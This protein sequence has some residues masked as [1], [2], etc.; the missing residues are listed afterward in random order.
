MLLF[1]SHPLPATQ[2]SAQ[3]LHTLKALGADSGRGS[4]R[5]GADVSPR[6][7][8]G[9]GGREKPRLSPRLSPP[10]LVWSMERVRAGPSPLLLRTAPAASALEFPFESCSRDPGAFQRP[11][12][13]L[14]PRGARGF[15]YCRLPVLPAPPCSGAA[16]PSFASFPFPSL[17]L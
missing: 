11:F 8:S 12:V 2:T 6:T 13:L 1:C 15:L 4:R 9:E 5:K 10:L 16:S 7:G 17:C 14:L 3:Y